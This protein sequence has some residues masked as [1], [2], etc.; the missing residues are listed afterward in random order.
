MEYIVFRPKQLIW[1]KQELSQ[2]KESVI[3]AIYKDYYKA[4]PSPI[5]H[6]HK[7]RNDALTGWMQ[8]ANLYWAARRQ[9]AEMPRVGVG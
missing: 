8:R 7:R 1:N 5:L 9:M 6:D 2:W 3:V 4:T